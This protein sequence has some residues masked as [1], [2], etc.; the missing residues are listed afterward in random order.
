[1]SN[2]LIGY[3]QGNEYQFPE[4]YNNENADNVSN[5]LI[6]VSGFDNL[7]N[8]YSFNRP[9][10]IV[11]VDYSSKVLKT[12]KTVLNILGVLCKLEGDI[13]IN[14]FRLLN[15]KRFTPYYKNDFSLNEFLKIINDGICN[16]D[17]FDEFTKLD[18]WS[19]LNNIELK[20]IKDFIKEDFNIRMKIHVLEKK[21]H[22]GIK[23]G[24]YENL[25]YFHHW[26]LLGTRAKKAFINDKNCL[27]EIANLWLNNGIELLNMNFVDLKLD[28]LNSSFKHKPSLYISFFLSNICD[29][30]DLKSSELFLSTMTKLT[31]QTRVKVIYCHCR[32]PKIWYLN[33]KGTDFLKIIEIGYHAGKTIENTINEYCLKNKI[34][35]YHH[36]WSDEFEIR[37]NLDRN[38]ITLHNNVYKKLPR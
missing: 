8:H 2:P 18:V 26:L 35:S 32:W 7:V 11:W 34:K 9:K 10:K 12:V 29:Y 19:K 27:Y 33:Q 38:E 25:S 22:W 28:K 31:S 3:H 24:S 15:F 37:N 21:Y 14:F 17:N 36:M 20:E 30:F 13:R 23:G 5:L 16:I 1:M 6:G 4:Y